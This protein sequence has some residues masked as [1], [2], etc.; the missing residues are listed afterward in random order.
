MPAKVMPAK[1]GEYRFW[2]LEIWQSSGRHCEMQQLSFYQRDAAA[3]DGLVVI[4]PDNIK[5]P[6]LEGVEIL[7][8]RTDIENMGDFPEDNDDASPRPPSPPQVRS[9]S[10]SLSLSLS[11]SYKLPRMRI[12]VSPTCTVLSFLRTAGTTSRGK[13][14]ATIS[15]GG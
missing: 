5:N 12:H 9:L 8:R 2:Q 11:S 1:V 15:A 10:L 3:D 14:L 13:A 6:D 4:E 7:P